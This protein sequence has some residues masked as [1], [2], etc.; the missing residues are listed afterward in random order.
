MRLAHSKQ[1][2]DEQ[3]AGSEKGASE[4]DQLQ[5]RPRL[6]EGGLVSVLVG[7]KTGGAAVIRGLL[8]VNTLGAAV[9][10]GL[11]TVN[12]LGAAV[13]RGLRHALTSLSSVR[14]RGYHT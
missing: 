6:V 5:T 14:R 11:L 13:I 1:R 10:R 2:A 3:L 9:M 7:R 12:M 4:A 8:T